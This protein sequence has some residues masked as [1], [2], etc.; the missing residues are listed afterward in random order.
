MARGLNLCRVRKVQLHRREV[1][2]AETSNPHAISRKETKMLS[3]NFTL[4]IFV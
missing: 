2:V 1:V 4:R 3:T